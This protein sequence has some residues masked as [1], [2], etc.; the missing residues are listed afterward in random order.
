[1]KLKKLVKREMGIEGY[2]KEEDLW[3][4]ESDDETGKFKFK[5]FRKEDM[6]CVELK[7]GKVFESIDLVRRAIREYSCQ[8]RWNIKM[9]V[10]DKKRIRAK[11]VGGDKEECIWYLWASYDSRTQCWQIKR[12]EG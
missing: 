6:R 11:C 5:T 12:Y 4:P 10:N 2:S 7:V 3:A 9:H 8:N 1:L